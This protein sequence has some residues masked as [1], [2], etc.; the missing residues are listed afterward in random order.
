MSFFGWE[1]RTHCIFFGAMLPGLAGEGGGWSL[2]EVEGW[3]RW[4]STSELGVPNF[5]ETHMGYPR[6]QWIIFFG[7]QMA[8]LESIRSILFFDQPYGCMSETNQSPKTGRKR[9][10]PQKSANGLRLNTT[11]LVGALVP[12]LTQVHQ[13]L[14]RLLSRQNST[15]RL[16]AALEARNPK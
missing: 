5:W 2:A 8:S 4:W 3:E 14:R 7:I 10:T 16:G 9:S 1:N 15:A 12:S 6:F 11:P 13:P